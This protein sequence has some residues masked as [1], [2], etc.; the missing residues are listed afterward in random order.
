[1]WRYRGNGV[2][3]TESTATM[4]KLSGR[5]GGKW[6]RRKGRERGSGGRLRRWREMAGR[7]DT[8]SVKWGGQGCRAAN[9]KI[10]EY[11]I[12]AFYPLNG[13]V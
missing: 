5:I 11:A 13:V 12:R 3:S 4:G 10:E 8:E 7:S 6:R 2:A 1:M 9:M